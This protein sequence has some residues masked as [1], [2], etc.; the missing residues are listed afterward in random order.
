[1][2]P[3]H[4][5]MIYDRPNARAVAYSIGTLVLSV[6]LFYQYRYSIERPHMAATYSSH[7]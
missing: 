1:M 7:T 4:Q 3:I 6:H 2:L 5:G